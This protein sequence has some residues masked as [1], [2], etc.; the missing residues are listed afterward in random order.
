MRLNYLRKTFVVILASMSI[1]AS[2]SSAEDDFLSLPLA[3]LMQTK[4][5]I[6]NKSEVTFLS[7]PASVS[8]FTSDDLNRLGEVDNFT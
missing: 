3:E 4:V 7:A 1:N 5:T 8:F 2:A 6:A